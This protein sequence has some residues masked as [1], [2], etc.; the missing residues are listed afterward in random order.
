MT[1]T[2]TYLSP[3]IDLAEALAG[4]LMRWDEL[5]MWA[6]N[7]SYA[8]FNDVMTPEDIDWNGRNQINIVPAEC[9]YHIETRTKTKCKC[10][11]QLL[12]RK[13]FLEEERIGSGQVSVDVIDPCVAVLHAI[14][15]KLCPS[16]KN[17]GAKTLYFMSNARWDPESR[18]KVLFNRALL[19]KH[20][21]F[22][23]L[24]D[25]YYDIILDGM[26]GIS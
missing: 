26:E 20:G 5:E 10:H 9:I 24:M 6:V 15:Q 1:Y 11:L 7:R 23:A 21:Q 12:M 22:T 13:M 19:V 8:D 3:I 17:Y 16:T 25:L 14:Y 18:L 2:S 4:E